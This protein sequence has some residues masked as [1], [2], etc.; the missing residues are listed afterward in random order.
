MNSMSTATD[1]NCCELLKDGRLQCSV[2]GYALHFGHPCAPDEMFRPA[3]K[4]WGS[5]RYPKSKARVNAWNE[6]HRFHDRDQMEAWVRTHLREHGF[7]GE[8]VLALMLGN[9]KLEVDQ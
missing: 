7:T 6:D 8:V 3:T 1:R 2:I 4:M 9:F 5:S